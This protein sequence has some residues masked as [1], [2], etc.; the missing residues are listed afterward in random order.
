MSPD[1]CFYKFENSTRKSSSFE[2]DYSKESQH[3]DSLDFLKDQKMSSTF[4]HAKQ[5]YNVQFKFVST[6]TGQLRVGGHLIE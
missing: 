6:A 2:K 4:C 1:F 3:T 5:N